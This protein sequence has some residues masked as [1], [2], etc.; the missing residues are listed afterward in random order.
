M[1]TASGIAATLPQSTSLNIVAESAADAEM[2]EAFILL[3]EE[4]RKRI[5]WH[6]LPAANT[7]Q[8]ALAFFPETTFLTQPALLTQT[9]IA[10]P[11]AVAKQTVVANQTA[12][13]S[14]PKPAHTAS[15]SQANNTPAPPAA[16]PSPAAINQVL[17]KRLA[18]NQAPVTHRIK[19]SEEL[20]RQQHALQLSYQLKRAT[21]AKLVRASTHEAAQ[22]TQSSF[23]RDGWPKLQISQMPVSSAY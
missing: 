23:K 13:V 18:S 11:P 21:Q 3:H 9:V 7:K 12:V 14:Q 4:P 19:K 22:L 2:P 17:V 20:L 15:V 6:M 10:S 5:F 16:Q 8:L 1:Y